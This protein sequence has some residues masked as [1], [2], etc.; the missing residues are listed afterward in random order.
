MAHINKNYLKLPER[1]LFA[2]VT[3][4]ANEFAKNH[5]DKKVL[6]LGVGDVTLPL[7]RVAVEAMKAACDEM[8]VQ[9]TFRGYGPEQGYDFLKQAIADYYLS[10]GV[11]LDL[12]DIFVSDGS[13]SD[14]GNLGDIFS[15]DNTVMIPDPVYPAYVDCNVMLDR[16]IIYIDGKEE[17][18]FLPTPGKEV[19]D[20]IY[21]CSPNNPTGAVYSKEQLKAWVD[22]AREHGSVILFDAAY[23][24]FVGDPNLPRS[25]Y[26]I[27]GAKECAIEICSFSKTAGFTGVRCGYTIVPKELVI[28]GVSLNR[29]WLR[30]QTTKFNGV[31]YIVQRGAAAVLSE[32]GQKQA[33]ELI[34][35]YLN[36]D[37][38]IADVL[39]EKG[40]KFMG[41]VNAPYIWMKCPGNMKSWEF[42]DYLLDNIAVVG[43]PGSGF[44][45]NGEGWFR[46]TAFG[47]R[48]NTAEAMERFRK[49]F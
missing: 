44:G 31:S 9:K 39:T 40:I 22:F 1:Y 33:K 12:D 46:L 47:Q 18:G 45:K 27:E 16:K 13:K 2:D 28:D 34:S 7:P 24:C 8:A 49:H 14:G 26:Q 41:G 32:E 48:E 11:T 30:R 35:Y 19:A 42:Y 29:L 6:R 20:I 21:L 23:E 43:T 10:H 37:K 25:I 5:P 4:R 17:N 15:N 38:I 36:N 3:R